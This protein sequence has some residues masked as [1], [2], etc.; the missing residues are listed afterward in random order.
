MTERGYTLIELSVVVLLVGM[1]LLIAVPR[2]RETLL[3]DDLKA[4]ARQLIGAAQELRNESVREQTDFALR[5]SLKE[6]SFWH[7]RADTQAEKLLEIRQRASRLPAGIGITAVRPAGGLPRADGEAVIR[8]F[9]QGYVSP[10]VLWLAKEQRT[11][12]LVFHPFLQTVTVYE[13]HVDFFFNEE[14]RAAGY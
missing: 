1:M 3:D 4:A 6:A 7:Y 8:F 12:T 14:D 5:I 9:R 2:V 10:T 13:E 11:L